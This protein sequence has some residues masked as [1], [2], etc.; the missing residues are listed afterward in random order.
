METN[1][2]KTHGLSISIFWK[3]QILFTLL[4]TVVFSVA[5]LWFFR[6]ATSLAEDD[7]RR[8]LAA[9]AASAASGIDGDA[10]QALYESDIPS[11]G[12]PT[13]DVRY[14]ELVSW[15]KLVKE[16]QGKLTIDGEEVFRVL[17]Y[18][19]VPTAVP[20]VVEFVGSSSALNDPPGGAEYRTSYT[21][22]PAEGQPNFMIG[23]LSETMVNIDYPIPDAWGQWVSAFSPIYNSQGEIVAAVGV[24]MRD[25]TVK[26]LQERIRNA[27]L[28]AFLITYGVL[29]IAVW[30]IAYQ[31]SRPL[32]T[33]THAAERVADGDY[34]E[35]VI[36]QINALIRDETSTLSDVFR[37]MVDKVAA[38]ERSLKKQVQELRIEIDRVKQQS[39]VSEIVETDFFQDLRVKAREMRKRATRED[40]DTTE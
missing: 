8:D 13:D 5:F 27:V 40:Q 35:G 29:F 12:R 20:G 4:F 6:F 17:L 21:T 31:I 28:P 1:Q 3:L 15:L 19:Y 7:L 38:R 18:T 32:R 24:D 30:A 11:G 36:P 25:T 2:E 23:G 26:A 9:I 16:S 22:N 37:Q 39:Q 34:S 33:L 10:H 14:L